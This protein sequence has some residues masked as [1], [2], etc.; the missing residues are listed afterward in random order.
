MNEIEDNINH[1]KRKKVQHI[2]DERDEGR[3]SFQGGYPS[4]WIIFDDQVII[5]TVDH[6]GG[7]EL[8]I[9]SVDQ[10]IK[11]NKEMRKFLS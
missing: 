8:E 5:A 1:P 9:I 2:I 7:P 6:D 3:F 11:N 10:L 4:Q